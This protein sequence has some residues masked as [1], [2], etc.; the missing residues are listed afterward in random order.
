MLGLHVAL[1]Q[2]EKKPLDSRR[3]VFIRPGKG[4]RTVV[5][6]FHI[7]HHFYL[8]PFPVVVVTSLTNCGV[9]FFG[10]QSE[11]FNGQGG[12]PPGGVGGYNAFTQAAVNGV[13]NA[14]L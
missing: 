11:P 2:R 6:S 14:V 12:L 7:Y 5:S 9:V 13:I 10:L 8:L 1:K 3:T 4:L